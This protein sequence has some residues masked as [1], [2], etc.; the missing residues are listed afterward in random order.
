MN[1]ADVKSWAIDGASH[2]TRVVLNGKTVWGGL[3]NRSGMHS[4]AQ[5]FHNTN[6]DQG[7]WRTSKSMVVGAKVQP[8]SLLPTST[9][10]T[11]DTSYLTR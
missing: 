2:G 3:G 9:T 8:R 11:V 4:F 7:R 10:D 6:R 5:E 1:A